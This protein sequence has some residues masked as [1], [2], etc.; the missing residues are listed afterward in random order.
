M[1]IK[2]SVP[3]PVE[4]VLHPDWW[5]DRIGLTFDEDFFYHPRR[6]VEAETAMEKALY[7][8]WGRFGLGG[9]T[10]EPQLGAV[11]LAAGFLVSEMMGCKVDYLENAPPLVH[12]ADL[13]APIVPKGDP[14]HSPAFKKFEALADSLETRYGA[15]RGDVN[16]GGVLN[17]ALDLRGQGIFMDIYDQPEET[18]AFFAR[19]SE[20][21]E[22]FTSGIA[23]RTGTTSVS[24]NRIVRYFDEPVFLHSECSHT[25]ISEAA[26][27][28]FLF[29]YD[30]AW[31]RVKRPFGIHYCGVDPHRFA[32]AF[33]RLPRLD[34]LDLGWGGDVALLRKAL[35]DTFFSLRLSPTAI[36]SMPAEEI[37]T[38]I[39]RLAAESGDPALTG[40]CCVN[41]DRNVSDETISALLESIEG[42][43]ARIG[44]RA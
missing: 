38:T 26:Y 23:A 44:K 37:R 10:S 6:R 40:F 31:S 13:E 20:V 7:E 11:H 16:W 35:P 30:E 5:N 27:D 18:S 1:S 33:S 25:M 17:V 41:M 19:I 43:R 2:A 39:E 42:L 3:Y 14:F 24:V 12:P 21:L 8:R 28:E 22:S 29:R 32:S 4:I 9:K 34:F 15:V 36:G